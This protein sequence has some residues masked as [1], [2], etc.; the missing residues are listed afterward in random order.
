MKFEFNLGS[1]SDFGGN[2][3]HVIR[4]HCFTCHI[5]TITT[6]RRGL[7][8]H[9]RL[10]HDLRECGMTRIRG[11]TG[12]RLFCDGGEREVGSTVVVGGRVVSQVVGGVVRHPHGGVIGHTHGRVA[13]HPHSGVDCTPTDGVEGL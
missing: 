12:M 4:F 5:S 7:Y 11:I 6:V 10:H 3:A 8:H 13:G 2:V 1:G 9:L